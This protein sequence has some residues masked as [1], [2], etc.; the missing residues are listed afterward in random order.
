MVNLLSCGFLGLL[1]LDYGYK[2]VFR[3]LLCRNVDFFVKF[4]SN[5]TKKFIKS[6]FGFLPL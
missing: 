6:D 1:C 4:N 2:C 3:G 5:K